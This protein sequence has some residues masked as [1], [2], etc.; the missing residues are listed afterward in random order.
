MRI[1]IGLARRLEH[2]MSLSDEAANELSNVRRELA[3]KFT[4]YT[5]PFQFSADEAVA[6][7]VRI[8]QSDVGDVD[9]TRIDELTFSAKFT[10]SEFV[11]FLIKK[12]RYWNL[13]WCYALALRQETGFDLKDTRNSILSGINFLLPRILMFVGLEPA[14]NEFA[15]VFAKNDK[16]HHWAKTLFL[17]V[18]ENTGS[19]TERADQLCNRYLDEAYAHLA[20]RAAL[21][22]VEDGKSNPIS[23]NKDMERYE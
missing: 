18:S 9:T 1:Y 12:Y 21:V 3:Y 13:L 10:R 22:E 7:M 20:D 14:A 19:W 15:Q 5:Q 6:A 17:S 11:E 16:S 23:Q 2:V 4:E 8:T